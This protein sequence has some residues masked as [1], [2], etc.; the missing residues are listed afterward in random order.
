MP[1]VANEQL[2]YNYIAASNAGRYEELRGYLSEDV[3]CHVPGRNVISGDH[4]G[5]AAV[6]NL[7]AYMERHQKAHPMDTVPVK[8]ASGPTY[9]ARTVANV[10]TLSED[11]LHWQTR[12]LYFFRQSRIVA[13]WLFIDN[14]NDYNRYWSAV[15]PT[16]ANVDEGLRS[17][18]ASLA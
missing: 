5:V 10:A 6:V 15:R 16:R 14:L 13:C 4:I 1:N 8:M 7:C 17:S 12:T 3:A 9:V 2:V 18:P 11:V